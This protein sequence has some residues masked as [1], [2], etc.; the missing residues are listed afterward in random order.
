MKEQSKLLGCAFKGLSIKKRSHFELW[1]SIN[2]NETAF[3]ALL[4]IFISYL[5]GSYYYY[6]L[7]LHFLIALG[8]IAF[9][10]NTSA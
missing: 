3:K 5:F 10:S 9:I 7:N 2:Y 4:K 6:P 1:A 8:S